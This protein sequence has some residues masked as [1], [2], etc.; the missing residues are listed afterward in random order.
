MALT[1]LIYPWD[2][3]PVPIM[4]QETINRSLFGEPTKESYYPELFRGVAPEEAGPPVSTPQVAPV[5]SSRR[6]RTGY[7]MRSYL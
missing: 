6:S 4:S 2:G 3:Y 5:A 1:N 7:G